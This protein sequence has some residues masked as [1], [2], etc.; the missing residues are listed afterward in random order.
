MV[1]LKKISNIKLSLCGK[2]PTCGFRL[3]VE[4]IFFRR[5]LCD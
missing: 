5:D 3:N 4:D 1:Y 2:L